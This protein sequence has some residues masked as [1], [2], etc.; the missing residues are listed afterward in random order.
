MK[1]QPPLTGKRTLHLGVV[2]LA[3]T[4]GALASPESRQVNSGGEQEKRVR[5]FVAAFNA[6]KLDVML[7]W[8]PRIFNGCTSMERRSPLRPKGNSVTR[9]HEAVLQQLLVM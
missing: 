2:V 4:I 3:M 5:E 9:K 1:T 8:R 7:S 6:R